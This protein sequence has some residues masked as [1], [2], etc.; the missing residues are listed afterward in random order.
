MLSQ[1]EKRVILA[2]AKEAVKSAVLNREINKEYWLSKYP[3]L[4]QKGAVFVTLNKNKN[5]RGCIGSIIAHQSLI[6]DIINNAKSA[7]LNDPRFRPVEAKELD[8]LDIEVS[9]LTTPKLLNYKSIDD[10]KR[11][12][13]PKIDGVIINYNGYQATYLP[14]VWR[15]LPDFDSFFATLCQKARLNRNCLELHP[16]IYTYEAIEIKD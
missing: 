1:E 11:K 14:S 12:I 2:L 13:R 5:L 7:A 3:W 6:D 16:T 8:K 15:Q 10:L 9:Y 4:N